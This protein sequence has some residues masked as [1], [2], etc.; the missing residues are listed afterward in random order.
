MTPVPASVPPGFMQ[1]PSLGGFPDTNGPIYVRDIDGKLVFG[2]RVEARHTNARG[3]CHGGMLMLL[4]DLQL[5][6]AARY[7]A[8]LDDSFLPT[9]NLT[10][11]FLAPANIGDWVT[12]ETDV[13]RTTNN[14]V[15]AQ[16]ILR[17]GTRA[18]LRANGIFK[19]AG[20]VRGEDVQTAGLD[21]PLLLAQSRAS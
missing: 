17:V 2:F 20:V 14:L 16:G 12:G 1:L 21:F 3:R 5:P 6:L 10:G 13:I 4:A 7:Q 9:I 15:F 11:D 8:D 19:R 18:I